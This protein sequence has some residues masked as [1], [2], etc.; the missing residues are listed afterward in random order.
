VDSRPELVV[1]GITGPVF[2]HPVCPSA[3]PDRPDQHS[4]FRGSSTFL[5]TLGN[6]SM[7]QGG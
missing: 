1:L 2:I 6:C 5:P 7:Y 3:Q 4:L